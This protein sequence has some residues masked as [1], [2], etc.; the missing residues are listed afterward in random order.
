MIKN[1]RA[2]ATTG[3]EES[4]GITEDNR[5]VG[6]TVG[7]L[8]VTIEDRA[9]G[10]ETVSE[11]ECRS[12]DYSGAHF[13]ST[14][15]STRMSRNRRMIGNGSRGI[16]K[17]NTGG[18]VACDKCVVA[19]NFQAPDWHI[20]GFQYIMLIGRNWRKANSRKTP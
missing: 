15:R 8:P 6:A 16:L 10:T 9:A 3:G 14:A 20:E 18:S 12:S 1:A 4:T 17:P 19:G 7:K 2:F 11:R 5:L 13:S